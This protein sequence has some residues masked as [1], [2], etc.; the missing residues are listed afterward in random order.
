MRPVEEL[1]LDLEYDVTSK[2]LST[3]ICI[4]SVVDLSKAVLMQYKE[5][6]TFL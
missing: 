6:L 2:Y 3:T 1:H 4:D 5:G